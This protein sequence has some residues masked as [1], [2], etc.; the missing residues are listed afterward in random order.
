[1]TKE[2][3]KSYLE[4]RKEEN[5]ELLQN[6]ISLY[7]FHSVALEVVTATLLTSLALDNI[8]KELYLIDR[9]ES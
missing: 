9:S 2:E 4:A 7:S 1:M 6:L 8:Y 5:E 3:Y